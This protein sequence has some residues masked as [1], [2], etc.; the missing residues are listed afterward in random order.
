MATRELHTYLL[1]SK[2][3]ISPPLGAAR[4]RN[5]KRKKKQSRLYYVCDDEERKQKAEA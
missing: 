1:S 3:R 5:R 2:F 4:S